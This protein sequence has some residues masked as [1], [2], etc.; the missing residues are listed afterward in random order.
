MFIFEIHIL[1]CFQVFNNALKTFMT[2]HN[3]FL[4]DYFDVNKTINLIQK[5][6]Y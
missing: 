3:D 1:I 6:I 4:I 5:K 2:Y